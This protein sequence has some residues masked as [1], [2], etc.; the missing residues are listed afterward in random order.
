MGFRTFLCCVE[1][2][3]NVSKICEKN[4]YDCGTLT[5]DTYSDAYTIHPTYNRSGHGAPFQLTPNEE[6]Y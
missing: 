6:V 3:I 4:G 5:E 2:A 1:V